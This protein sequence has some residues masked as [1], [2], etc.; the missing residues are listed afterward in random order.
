M[1]ILPGSEAFHHLCM[2]SRVMVVQGSAPWLKFAKNAFHMP[3]DDIWKDLEYSGSVQRRCPGR[4]LTCRNDS[5][6]AS[7]PLAG[8]ISC[9]I[10]AT[11]LSITSYAVDLSSYWSHRSRPHCSSIFAACPGPY[12]LVRQRLKHLHMARDR[13]LIVGLITRF[14]GLKLLMISCTLAE[15]AVGRLSME[16][17][18]AQ[19]PKD[20]IYMG[21]R[22]CAQ[23]LVMALKLR[24]LQEIGLKAL[25][26]HLDK[27]GTH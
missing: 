6:A 20:H 8:H 10:P 12:G 3:S 9:S 22:A 16:M 19:C 11:G 18:P 27:A 21:C 1:G 23:Q 24:L 15:A 26:S 17:W 14:S 13:A 7:R 25:L 5:I 4:W 2:A